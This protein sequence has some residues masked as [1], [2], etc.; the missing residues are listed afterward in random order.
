[1]G[2][3]VEVGKIYG[4][5]TV[6]SEAERRHG[7]RYFRCRCECGNE[8]EYPAS[9]ILRKPD[10]HCR[11]CAPHTGGLP[12]PDYTGQTINGWKVLEKVDRVNGNVAFRCRCTKCGTE[13]VHNAGTIRWSKGNRCK[14][15]ARDYHFVI[16]EETATGCLFNG[17]EFLIDA[18][19]IEKVSQQTWR[20]DKDGYI[21]HP[22]KH[23]KRGMMLHRYV[24]GI[25]DPEVIV[26][27]INRDRKDCRKENLRIISP[28]G[29]SC[30]HKI[31]DTNKT[32]YTGVYYSHHAGRYEVKIGYN[33]KRIKLGSSPDDLITLAQMY[34]VGAQFLFG[35]YAGELNDV[36]PP[37]EDL[38]QRVIAKC[39]KYK[40]APAAIA[41]ASVM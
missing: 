33:Y 17:T 4:R 30:N 8:A 11:K 35:E 7:T 23:G 27:H 2:M 6:I 31:F 12:E 18:E 40:E 10:R 26:D 16:E 34:N 32:G 39:Q 20:M 22:G 1:M 3:S 14:A 25:T 36:P 9:V 28:F 13:S 21:S 19:D 5:F 15:C 37:S 24:A 38:T 29:N 41:G